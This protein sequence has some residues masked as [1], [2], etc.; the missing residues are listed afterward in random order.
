MQVHHA[1]GDPKNNGLSNLVV[2]CLDC[3]AKVS[4]KGGIGKKYSPKEVIQYKRNW[5]DIV[6][7]R[8]G[9]IP[10]DSPRTASPTIKETIRAGDLTIERE[11]RGVDAVLQYR[12]GTSQSPH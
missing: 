2:L 12:D 4:V 8:L 9:L 3:Y 10:I 1:D 7:K 6:K 5:E 11:F